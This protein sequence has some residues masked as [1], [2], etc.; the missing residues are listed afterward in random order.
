MFSCLRILALLN[1]II[2]LSLL[3]HCIY[4]DIQLSKQN[5]GDLRNRV[6][7]ARLQ[8]DGKDPYFY[9][10]K[11]ED[12]FRYFDPANQGPLAVSNITATPFFHDLLFPVCNW[13]QS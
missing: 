8:K 12:G 3:T 5:T 6:V 10:W 1:Y 9:K 2:L 13:P 11:K 7:G 4:R